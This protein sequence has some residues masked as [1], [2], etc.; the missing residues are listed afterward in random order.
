MRAATWPTPAY[1]LHG[2]GKLAT[3]VQQFADGVGGVTVTLGEFDHIR[4]DPPDHA[5]HLHLVPLKKKRRGELSETTC[6]LIAVTTPF[7]DLTECFQK[8][9]TATEIRGFGGGV[10]ERA[11][12]FLAQRTN[13]SKPDYF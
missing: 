1:L 2:D 13:S 12:V 7:S 5:L 6:L 10:V 4:L 8:K 9:K 3:L 11:V